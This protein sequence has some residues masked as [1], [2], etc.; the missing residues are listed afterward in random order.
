MTGC[1]PQGCATSIERLCRLARVSRAG[2]YRFWHKS[3]PRQLDTTVRDAI[4][5]LALANGPHRGYLVQLDDAYLG[6]EKRWSEGSTGVR[7]GHTR[8]LRHF[9]AAFSPWRPLSRPARG[10]LAVAAR[11]PR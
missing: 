1:I 5:R 3:A 9:L 4:Q 7:S 8:E 10:G 6:G 2:Y 11:F